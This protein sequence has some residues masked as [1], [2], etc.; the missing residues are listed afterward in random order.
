MGEY[1]NANPWMTQTVSANKLQG[2]STNTIGSHISELENH[3]KRL[4]EILQLL[5][6]VGDRLLGVRPEPVTKGEA[7]TPPTSITIALQ[8]KA[9]EA[10]MLI[11]AIGEAAS[12]VESALGDFR[13]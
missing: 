9:R 6:S 7:D 13:G 12:R 10:S 8:R 11:G 5:N 1:G 3:N 4:Y 2:A